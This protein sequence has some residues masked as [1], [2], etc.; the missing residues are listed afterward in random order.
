MQ[1]HK[2]CGKA[3]GALMR[4]S[5]AQTA[6]RWGWDADFC[7]SGASKLVYIIYGFDKI[8]SDV[9]PVLVRKGQAFVEKKMN[10]SA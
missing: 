10:K 7:I 1:W 8:L 3:S 9:D 6:C 2:N 4:E 5:G